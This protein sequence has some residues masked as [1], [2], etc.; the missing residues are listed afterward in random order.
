MLLVGAPGTGKTL[1]GE[2]IADKVRQPLYMLS[3]AELGQ[4]ADQV[5]DKLHSVLRLT[6]KWKAVLLLDECD[7]FLE[8]RSQNNLNHNE[9]V[10]LR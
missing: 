8:K 10:F 9:V 7:V 2:A 1:T 4:E 5:E 6:N 3:A